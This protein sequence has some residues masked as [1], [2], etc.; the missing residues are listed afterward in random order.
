[1]CT[2]HFRPMDF[3]GPVIQM[4]RFEDVFYQVRKIEEREGTH[5]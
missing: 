1:M 5:R 4:G 3:D 2:V